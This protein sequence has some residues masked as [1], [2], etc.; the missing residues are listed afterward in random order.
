MLQVTGTRTRYVLDPWLAKPPWATDCVKG[1]CPNTVLDSPTPPQL[2]I[3]WG[4]GLDPENC[5]FN[6]CTGT[7]DAVLGLGP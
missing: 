2:Q 5:I 4:P 3:L 6:R 1:A 7:R